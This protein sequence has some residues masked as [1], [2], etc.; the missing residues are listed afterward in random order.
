MFDYNDLTEISIDTTLE[1][2]TTTEFTY[3]VTVD[4]AA[5]MSSHKMRWLAINDMNF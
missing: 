4:S 2:V 3:R 5:S 1:S